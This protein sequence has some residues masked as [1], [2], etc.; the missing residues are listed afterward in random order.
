MSIRNPVLPGFHPDPA[1][2]RAGT[3]YYI[4]TSTFEWH[5]GVRLHHS[6]DLVHWRPLGG[7]LDLAREGCH[8]DFRLLPW[9][10]GVIDHLSRRSPANGTG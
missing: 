9:R 4:A 10:L 2:V 5:P 3:D 6:R 8:A 1:I 7:V